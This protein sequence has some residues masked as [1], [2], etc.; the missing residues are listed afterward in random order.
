MNKKI[1]YIPFLCL[2]L[3]A[4]NNQKQPQADESKTEISA[5]TENGEMDRTNSQ[6]RINDM[7]ANVYT[8]YIDGKG[9]VFFQLNENE[10]KIFCDKNHILCRL[11]NAPVKIEGLDQAGKSIVTF[12]SGSELFLGILTTEGKVAFIDITKAISTGDTQCSGLLPNLPDATSIKGDGN[13]LLAT[14]K[15]GNEKSITAFHLSGYYLC[16]DFEIQL[17]KDYR[18]YLSSNSADVHKSGTFFSDPT[19]LADGP[20]MSSLMLVANIEG[21]RYN[22]RF[23]YDHFRLAENDPKR[24]MYTFQFDTD[25]FALMK[26]TD[27]QFKRHNASQTSN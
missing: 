17:T 15:E 6:E 18:I 26:N 13:S 14:D 25:D 4:C 5:S 16:N 7:V 20:D 2:G 9:N 11:D 24:S 27:I 22:I 3:V 10:A 21:K 1:V 8:A 23:G 19:Q 12:G